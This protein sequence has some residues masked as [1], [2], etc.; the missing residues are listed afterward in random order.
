MP[1][2]TVH[3]STRTVYT[4]LSKFP[5]F[6]DSPDA[7]ELSAVRTSYVAVHVPVSTRPSRA[8]RNFLL[9][10]AHAHLRILVQ[11]RLFPPR[12]ATHH[13]GNAHNPSVACPLSSASPR[14]VSDD[15]LAAKDILCGGEYSSQVFH[16]IY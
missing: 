11:T 1:A 10:V 13:S 14:M 6:T 15:M 9:L 8:S 5:T 4:A 16:C 12:T 7:K 2:R 3:C